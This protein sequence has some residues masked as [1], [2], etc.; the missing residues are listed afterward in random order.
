[1]KE[2]KI[3]IVNLVDNKVYRI[4]NHNLIQIHHVIDNNLPVT[5]DVNIIVSIEKHSKLVSKMIIIVTKWENM[6]IFIV[7]YLHLTKSTYYSIGK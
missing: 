3:I 2:N 6:A 1:M 4:I 5:A 7:K